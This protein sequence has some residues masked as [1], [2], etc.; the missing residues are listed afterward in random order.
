MGKEQ[1]DEERFAYTIGLGALLVAAVAACALVWAV[2]L[3]IEVLN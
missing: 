2:R 1:L 3:A